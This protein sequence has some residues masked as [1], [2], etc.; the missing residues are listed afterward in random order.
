M[1]CQ[2]R[3]VRAGHFPG[4]GPASE[5]AGGMSIHIRGVAAFRPDP[6]TQTNTATRDA[7]FMNGSTRTG[8]PVAASMTEGGWIG[9]M[10]GSSEI[11]VAKNHSAASPASGSGGQPV[12][13]TSTSKVARGRLTV[14]RCHTMKPWC[15]DPRS[16]GYA[17]ICAWPAIARS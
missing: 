3:R 8:S 17:A 10:G 2:S 16:R 5:L 7:Y 15:F 9:S 14:V 6:H 12:S 13:R 1:R 4:P 11:S